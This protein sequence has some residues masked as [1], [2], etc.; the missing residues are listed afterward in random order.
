MTGH[1]DLLLRL[2]TSVLCVLLQD[3]SPLPSGDE[4][5]DDEEVGADEEG[6]K[7]AEP[8]T[9]G[10]GVDKSESKDEGAKDDKTAEIQPLMSVSTEKST[11]R[12]S[13]ASRLEG[14]S[15]RVCG[16]L[17][18]TWITFCTNSKDNRLLQLISFL[19]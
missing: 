19:Q 5:S 4:V 18:C 17:S 15:Q 1:N 12:A 8:D 16:L 7:S 9:E 2:L 14:S 13:A 10:E 6:K 11:V 3:D